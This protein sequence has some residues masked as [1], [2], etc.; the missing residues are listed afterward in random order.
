VTSLLGDE[1]SLWSLAASLADDILAKTASWRLEMFLSCIRF[2]AGFDFKFLAGAGSLG[3]VYC[4]LR[5]ELEL[6]L[7][8][9]M[10]RSFRMVIED[11]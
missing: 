2:L 8:L 10:F 7:A 11:A 4:F 3:F 9:F 5:G 1:L 6:V